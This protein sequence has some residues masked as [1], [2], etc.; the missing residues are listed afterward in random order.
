MSSQSFKADGPFFV[1]DTRPPPA[2]CSDE[3]RAYTDL[4]YKIEHEAHVRVGDHPR[5]VR[6][7]GWDKRG[8][9]FEK[10]DGGD[11]LMYLLTHRDPTPALS[12]RIQWACDVAEG[13]AFLHSKGVIWVDVSMANVLLTEDAQRA[14]ICDL[15]GVCILPMPGFKPLPQPYEETVIGVH[16]MLGLPPF[17]NRHVWDGEGHSSYAYISPHFDRF[18]YGIMLFSLLALHFP[19]S[20]SFVVHDLPESMNIAE[21][22]FAFEFDTLGDVPEYAAFEAIIQKCFRAQYISSDDLVADLKA[23]AAAMPKDAPLLQTRIE[24]PILEYAVPSDGRS[25]YPFERE[26]DG[27]DDWP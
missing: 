6:Y 19:H 16:P 24:D 2:N 9:L 7:H 18:G 23:A 12:T 26:Y 22:Q 17:P 5:I 1:K 14:I 11:M 25:V 13:M 20:R 21:R 4:F 15:G 27:E 3:I 10:H 8:L